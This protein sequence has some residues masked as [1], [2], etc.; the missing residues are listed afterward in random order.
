MKNLIIKTGKFLLGTNTARQSEL[1]R[2]VYHRQ[3]NKKVLISY[4]TSPFTEELHDKHT[5]VLE[6]YTACQIF[7]ELKFIVDVIDYNAF[8]KEIVYSEYD[9]IYG[10]G[11][12][13]ERFFYS[14]SF[15][16]DNK[17]R[18]I[19]YGTGCDTVYS[20]K[21]SLSRVYEFLRRRVSFA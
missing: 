7:D 13:L 21:V 8:D 12:S 2:N 5:N 4:I 16:I 14:D 6:C 10:F 17:I 20:N 9:V 11:E 18:T 15:K 1:I 19:V 3:Y